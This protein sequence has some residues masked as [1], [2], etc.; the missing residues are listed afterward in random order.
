MNCIIDIGGGASKSVFADGVFDFLMDQ[1]I[2]FDSCI[3][4]SAGAANCCSYVSG[5]RGRN[6]NF[7]TQYNLEPRAIGLPAFFRTR[8]SWIDLDYIYGTLSNSDGKCPL[9][10]EAFAASDMKATLVVTDALTAEPVYFDK[11]DVKKDDY[12]IICAS[13]ANPEFCKA[14]MHDRH[15]YFDGY[16][17]DPIPVERAL[18]AGCDKIVV[19]LPFPKDHLRSGKRDA[20]AAAKLAKKSPA[21]SAKLA[22]YSQR[23][24]RQLKRALELEKEG[25]CLIVS[26]EHF[27]DMKP[28]EKDRNKIFAFHQAGYERASMIQS[29]L[30]T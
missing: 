4:V 8:G 16:V 20:K 21:V 1:G 22:G 2:R 30:D 12:W 19:L 25:V 18:A 29:F 17:S 24:N 28:M 7:Y 10:Y 15:P 13:S 11:S 23:Y 26:P 27:S 14:Y 3:G 9:D 6:L 5:Q